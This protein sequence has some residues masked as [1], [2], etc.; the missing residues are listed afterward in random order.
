MNGPGTAVLRSARPF[1]ALASSSA[2]LDHREITSSLMVLSRCRPLLAVDRLN[3]KHPCVRRTSRCA[4]SPPASSADSGCCVSGTSDRDPS[5]C[6]LAPCPKQSHD[7]PDT[8][9]SPNR[10]HLPPAIQGHVDR[11]RVKHQ[12]GI[13]SLFR[14]NGGAKT[15]RADPDFRTGT[16][17]ADLP[18]RVGLPGQ[19]DSPKV[20]N[21]NA[22]RRA[23]VDVTV[24]KTSQ[25]NGGAKFRAAASSNASSST[26]PQ[27]ASIFPVLRS[28]DSSP[29]PLHLALSFRKRSSCR[30]NVQQQGM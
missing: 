20:P 18:F 13:Q 11:D 8:V 6:S 26:W 9:P 24:R 19:P 15:R 30:R 12:P 17:A 21:N 10:R 29:T 23:G 4:C 1:P 5:I 28:L 22:R 25:A 7:L 27:P 3:N 16:L 14:V 2:L